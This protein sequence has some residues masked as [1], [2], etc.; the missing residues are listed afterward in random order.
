MILLLDLAFL[1]VVLL[2]IGAASVAVEQNWHGVLALILLGTLSY[3][4]ISIGFSGVI[5]WISANISLLIGGFVLY[6]ILGVMWSFFKW[7]RYVAERASWFKDLN[8]TPANLVAPNWTDNK[9]KITTWV[10]YWPLSG[11]NYIFGRLITD[12]YNWIISKLGGVY[13]SITDRHFKSLNKDN[14]KMT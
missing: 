8:K 1:F 14:D 5:T 2:A 13:Q 7:D 11:I 9:L 12:L 10:I 3:F 6:T 4:L